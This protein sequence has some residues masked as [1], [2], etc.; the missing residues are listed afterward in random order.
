ME[1]CFGR[2]TEGK[3]GGLTNLVEMGRQEETSVF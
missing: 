2:K 3:C 1:H